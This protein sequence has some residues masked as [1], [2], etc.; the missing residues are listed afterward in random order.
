MEIPPTQY[1]H[2]FPFIDHGLPRDVYALQGGVWRGVIPAQDHP[3]AYLWMLERSGAFL[4]REKIW[5]DDKASITGGHMHVGSLLEVC[6]ATMC[7]LRRLAGPVSLAPTYQLAL[8]LN[9]MKQRGVV[10]QRESLTSDILVVDEVGEVSA[11]EHRSASIP[12]KLETI[13]S[14]PLGVVYDLVAEALLELRPDLANQGKLERQLRLRHAF[15]DRRG[16]TRFLGFLDDLLAAKPARRAV[17]SLHHRRVGLLVE[18][19]GGS[20]FTYDP[21]YVGLPSARPLS[22]KLP[23]RIEP[24]EASGLLPF[25]ENLLPE[26]AQLEILARQRKLDPTDKFGIL[27]ATLPSSIGDVQIHQEERVETP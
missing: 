6:A 4:Y 7:F 19:T 21:T 17:V 9:G 2:G 12:T 13:V 11:E 27:L 23:V 15:D 16:R 5:E 1:V 25:F 14:F 3:P 20:R 24:Y 8:A 22:P 26:G 10:A 18:T